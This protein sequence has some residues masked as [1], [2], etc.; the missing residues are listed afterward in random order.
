M[1]VSLYLSTKDEIDTIS[2]LK[3]MFETG[4]EVFVPQY[5]GKNMEM[6]HL[7]SME[8]YE[9]LPLTKWNIK[10]PCRTE[11]RKNALETGELKN[12]INLT[13]V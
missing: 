10:Q 13:K 11:Y 6:V 8:D 2:I 9:T 12:I 3:H 5:H 1:R 4:K 7:K